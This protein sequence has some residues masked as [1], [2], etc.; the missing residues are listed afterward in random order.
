MK[1]FLHHTLLILALF[2]IIYPL[3]AWIVGRSSLPS[4]V[5]YIPNNYGHLALRLA[6]ADTAEPQLLFIGSSHCYRTFDTRLYDSLGLRSFNLGSS[7]QTPLQSF[8]LL[9]RYMERW[10]P[11]LVVVEVHP[12]VLANDGVESAVDMLSNS[13]MDH[14][15][16]GMTASLKNIRVFNT[17]LCSAID[18]LVNGL[19]D[20]KARPVVRLPHP[21]SPTDS[22]EFAYVKGGFVETT[23]LC[24]EPKELEPMTINVKPLQLKRLEMIADLLEAHGTKY[25][26]VEVP[27]SH[28]RYNSYLN[29]KQFEQQIESVLPDKSLYINFN[30]DYRLTSLLDDSTCYYDDDHLNQKGIRIFNNYFITKCISY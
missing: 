29:H 30:D 15:L 19:P 1:S 3:S 7:N 12:D 22:I 28:R 20:H 24:W 5:N 4:N 2:L 21:Y 25:L 18:H 13:A 9:S 11:D 10:K 8:L 17:M 14:R 26:F 23:Q 6:E 27:A 16:L